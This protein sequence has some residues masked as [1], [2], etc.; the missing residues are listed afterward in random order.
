MTSEKIRWLGKRRIG[1]SDA[2]IIVDWKA[3]GAIPEGER[4]YKSIVE[5]WAEKTGAVVPDDLEGNEAVEWGHLLEPAIRK[6]CKIEFGQPIVNPG[7]YAVQVH[8][9]HDYMTCTLDGLIESANSDINSLFDSHLGK[10]SLSGPGIVQIKTAGFYMRD[11]WEGSPPLIYQ[12][13]VQHEM[14]VFGADWSILAALVAGNRFFAYPVLRDVA[15]CDALCRIEGEFWDLVTRNVQPEIDDSAS[16]AKALAKMYDSPTDSSV[17]LGD[18]A[19][20]LDARRLEAMRI[21]K[22][23]DKTISLIDNK[24][25]NEI[26]NNTVGTLPSGVE[27]SWQ[28]QAR[29]A[30]EVPAKTFRVLRRKTKAKRN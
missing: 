2:P 1:G 12:A 9:D 22:S 14:E 25:K 21:R 29:A 30:Y 27:Y 24:I 13:Q 6:K 3:P 11:K 8:K 26:G 19:V 4:P 10:T 23:I 15:F 7:R 20:I 28:E 18:E 16:T 5:L 17:E